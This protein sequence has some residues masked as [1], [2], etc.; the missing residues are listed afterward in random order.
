MAYFYNALWM[1]NAQVSQ[2]SSQDILSIGIR[3]GR[4]ASTKTPVRY[5]VLLC[6]HPKGGGIAWAH[7]ESPYVMHLTRQS[8]HSGSQQEQRVMTEYWTLRT[9][10]MQPNCSP[11]KDSH[12][13]KNRCEEKGSEWGP[14]C[15]KVRNWQRSTLAEEAEDSRSRVTWSKAPS[16]QYMLQCPIKLHLQSTS[17]K[18]KSLRLSTWWKQSIKSQAILNLGACVTTHNKSA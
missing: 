7:P 10:V 3:N 12:R 15:L 14:G 1:D 13:C 2:S 16:F 18:I 6:Y 8:L 17:W 5:A 4:E 11:A 9:P